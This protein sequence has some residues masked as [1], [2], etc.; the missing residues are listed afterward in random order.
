MVKN[1]WK[2]MK[3]ILISYWTQCL[4]HLRVLKVGIYD[5]ACIK[6]SPIR[7]NVLYQKKKKKTVPPWKLTKKF[8]RYR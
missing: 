6:Y 7:T 5:K 2:I 4:Y 3:C 1:E 8:V